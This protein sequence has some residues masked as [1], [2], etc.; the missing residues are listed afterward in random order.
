MTDIRLV[1]SRLRSGFATGYVEGHDAY[2]ACYSDKVDVRHA[3]AHPMDR[4]MNRDE[5]V[6]L[7]RADCNVFRAAIADLQCVAQVQIVDGATIELNLRL[8]GS[9][10]GRAIVLPI[11][12]LLTVQHGRITAVNALSMQVG[13]E[14]IISLIFDSELAAAEVAEFLSLV[15]T[16]AS[17]LTDI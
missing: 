4:L 8:L 12:A 9:I 15:G 2:M 3:P 11:T 7:H 14:E 10:D 6:K 13:S 5:L 17:D 16:Q 1:A